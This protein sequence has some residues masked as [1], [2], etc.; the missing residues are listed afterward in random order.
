MGSPNGAICSRKIFSP[1]TQPISISLRYISVLS[2]CV[3]IPS[4]PGFKSESL[5]FIPIILCKATLGKLFL[6]TNFEIMLSASEPKVY[7][8]NNGLKPSLQNRHRLKKFLVNLFK[9]ENIRLDSINYIFCTDRFLLNANRLYLNHNYYTDIITFNLSDGNGDSIKAE[10]YISL[11]RV[12]ENAK[13]LH[14]SLK[15]ELHRVIF[16]GALHLCGYN[17]STEKEK[18]IMRSK[19]D[20]YLSQ[21]FS[22]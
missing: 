17:D 5:F 10:V 16:H 13:R 12:R 14:T 3:I 18:G 19:E 4:C 21:Y 8:F 9:N 6:F 20:L 11:Q 7:F 1:G 15:S 2:N 22:K